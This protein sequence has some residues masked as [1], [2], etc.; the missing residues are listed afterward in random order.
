MSTV[1]TEIVETDI[2]NSRCYLT[3]P[4]A[5]YSD[6]RLKK[7]ELNYD[8]DFDQD[9][10]DLSDTAWKE[11][12]LSSIISDTPK[13]VTLRVSITNNTNS[14]GY[15]DLKNKDVNETTYPANMFRVSIFAEDINIQKEITMNI[16]SND[17]V[18]Y[19]SSGLENEEIKIAVIGWYYF[20]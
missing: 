13:T 4:L 12:D 19:R 1:T 16:S 9:D 7:R 14:S 3:Y 5:E 20:E 17:I 18:N 10:L 2:I 8:W 11:L 6:S 15:F